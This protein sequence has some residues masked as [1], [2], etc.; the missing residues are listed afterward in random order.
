[1]TARQGSRKVNV[2]IL[3][4]PSLTPQAMAVVLYNSLIQDNDSTAEASYHIEGNIDLGGLPPAPINQ[5]ASSG[6]PLSAA[7]RLP[8]WRARS[9]ADLR[10][11]H[12]PKCHARD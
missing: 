11:P 6:Q 1:M 7:M 10:E 12:P 5:W 8:S 2:E 4:L 9:S 3:D